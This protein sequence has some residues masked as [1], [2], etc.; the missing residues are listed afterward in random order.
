MD[1]NK[2]YQRREL[3]GFLNQK[4]CYFDNIKDF[5]ESLDNMDILEQIE[6]I[7][8]GSY[9][10]GACFALQLRLKQLTPR[11]N[12]LANIGSVVLHAFY[13]RPFRYWHKLPSRTQLKINIAVASWLSSEHNFEEQLID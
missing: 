7:E 5:T 9:G 10:A 1:D 2:K 13:G 6:W 3:E 12:R 4:N 11:M 8:N